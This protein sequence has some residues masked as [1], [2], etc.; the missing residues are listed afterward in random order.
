[1]CTKTEFNTQYFSTCR[2]LRFSLE[3]RYCYYSFSITEW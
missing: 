3:M 1:M 2:D